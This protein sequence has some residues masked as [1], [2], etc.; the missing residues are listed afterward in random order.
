[1][2]AS[3]FAV[4]MPSTI[5]SAGSA[6]AC[7]PFARPW[8]M[9]VAWPVTDACGGRLDRR[10]ARRR[11][12]V[13]DHEQRRGHGEADQRA[14]V[15]VE[16]AGRLA[17]GR[18][19]EAEVVHHPRGHGEDEQRRQHA[20]QDQ[21]L[22]ERAL[23]VAGRRLDRE[24]ADDRGDDRD[25]AEHE[26]EEHDGALVLAAERQHAEQHHG[27]GGDR[28]GLEQVRRHAGAVA[29][30]VADVVG[31]HG[32]VARVVLGDARPRSCRRC[33]RRRRRPS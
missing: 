5:T 16:P 29:D 30:V 33:R 3:S 9:F 6:V 17:A 25:A 23:D 4:K 32:R 27:H 21:A 24:R 26:R 28:V 11:V 1:M 22:V 12:V 19:G 15:D 2:P 8:M 18:A 10:E 7:M 13:G 20:G 14:D 31:D